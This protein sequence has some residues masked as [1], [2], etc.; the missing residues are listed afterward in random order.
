M[1]LSSLTDSS[2]QCKFLFKLWKEEILCR[3]SIKGAD[4]KCF[5]FFFALILGLQQILFLLS[6]IPQASVICIC[7]HSSA[8]N[9][10]S[11]P[12]V[13][14]ESHHM[15]EYYGLGHGRAE[16]F[17]PR[18]TRFSSGHVLYLFIFFKLGAGEKNSLFN[19]TYLLGYTFFTTFTLWLRWRGT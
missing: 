12:T 16:A 5:F 15:R 6:R 19:R 17:W 9:C 7:P 10:T 13:T 4:A 18:S 2:V 11:W 14:E 1:P 8:L 3:R